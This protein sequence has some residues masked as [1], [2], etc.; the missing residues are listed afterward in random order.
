MTSGDG[1]AD[2]AKDETIKEAVRDRIRSIHVT[3]DA[4]NR[5]SSSVGGNYGKHYE[6]LLQ[7]F[8]LYIVIN[9]KHYG[10]NLYSFKEKMEVLLNV[11]VEQEKR[12]AT[13]A[14]NGMK[15]SLAKLLGFSV[16]IEIDWKFTRHPDFTSKSLDDQSKVIRAIHQNHLPRVLTSSDG[17]VTLAKDELV[18]QLLKDQVKQFVFVYDPE[19]QVIS[20]IGGNYG[21]HYNVTLASCMLLFV[22]NMKQYTDTLYGSIEKMEGSLNV[23]IPKE[24]RDAMKALAALQNQLST[25]LG[26]SVELDV[27]WSFIMSASFLSK[28]LDE[29]SKI[30]QSIWKTALPRLVAGNDSIPAILN[31]NGEMKTNALPKFRKLVYRIDSNNSVNAEVGDKTWEIS[32]QPPVLCVSVNMDQYSTTFYQLKDKLT[33]ALV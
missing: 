10:D 11:R 1:L 19:N 27:D 24:K 6:L 30:I 33:H 9:M 14:L 21:K 29:Y 17:I 4:E 12:T 28:S 22:V 25:G 20:N 3:Y 26:E 31:Q 32:L 13:L 18:H 7:G 8:D 15:E 16:D 2:L 23:R 5:I